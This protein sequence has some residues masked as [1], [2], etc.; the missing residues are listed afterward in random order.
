MPLCRGRVSL[1]LAILAIPSILPAQDTRTA[2]IEQ[3]R[4]ERAATLRPYEPGRLEKLLLHVERENPIGKIA[5][6]NGFFVEYGYTGK[7]T[8]SGIGAGVGYRRDLFDRRARVVFETGATSRH[9]RLV[10]ADFSV[11]SLAGGRLELGVEATDRHH[12]EEDFYGLGSASQER[13]RVSFLFDRQ[14]LQGRAVATLVDGLRIGARVARLGTRIGAGRDS[15]FPS[16]EQRFGDQDAPGLSEQPGYSYGDL[17][18]AFDRRDQPGN[19][20][21]GGYYGVLWRRYSDID[22]DRYSFR[23]VEADLQHFFP[24]FDKKR[25]F[26]VR[27]RVFTTDADPGQTVPFYFRPT[28]GG[29]DSL[30][31]ARDFRFRDTNVLALNLEYRW[32]A[33]SGLDMALF[34]DLGKV[35]TRTAQLDLTDLEQAYGVGLRF[36]TYKAVFLRLDVSLAGGESPRYFIRFRKA[37]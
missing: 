24:I 7:P 1:F 5:P 22:L 29:S 11:P 14:E 36:N 19:P 34:S 25:V 37:F 23:A 17:F 20:R 28:L 31:S 26:A 3:L 16:I 27:G 18:A 21:A 15:R 6:R 30:R 2:T 4:A 12:P 35:A 13:N 32:E 8:G 10:R 9:Y 33:F